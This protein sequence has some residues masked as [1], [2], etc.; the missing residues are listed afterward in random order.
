MGRQQRSTRCSGEQEL[1]GP[2]GPTSAPFAPAMGNAAMAAALGLGGGPIPAWSGDELDRWAFGEDDGEFVDGFLDRVEQAPGRDAAT[3]PALRERCDFEGPVGGV[4]GWI[5]ATVPV[6]VGVAGSVEL[7]IAL[8]LSAEAEMAC[9]FVNQGRGRCEI[10][11]SGGLAGGQDWGLGALIGESGGGIEGGWRARVKGA[12]TLE[13]PWNE[14]IDAETLAL[15]GASVKGEV[16]VAHLVRALADG[17]RGRDLTPYVTKVE[18]GAEGEL[19]LEAEAELLGQEISNVL[20]GVAGLKVGKSYEDPDAAGRREGELRIEAAAEALMEIALDL[21]QAGIDTSAALPHLQ[22]SAALVLPFV[23]TDGVPEY[24]AA[25]AEVGLDLEAG[26]GGIGGTM[27]LGPDHS[28]VSAYV[29]IHPGSFLWQRVLDEA[30]GC[31]LEALTAGIVEFETEGSMKLGM[32]LTLDQDGH[33]S[34][35]TGLI[36]DLYRWLTTGEASDAL[37]PHLPEARAVVFGAKLELE[38]DLIVAALHGEFG[39]GFGA[40]GEV[41]GDLEGDLG[42]VYKRDDV[43]AELRT[44][45]TPDEALAQM[46]GGAA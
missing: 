18:L 39:G 45:L 12:F 32:E 40:G 34:A 27:A 10:E 1:V 22:G 23:E 14:V 3:L 38:V 17:L 9:S 11:A 4:G 2:R 5:D 46:S 33:G 44:P 41:E 25:Y 15:L 31:K 8:G 6:G 13:M 19:G 28:A 37:V 29:M 26:V 24:R 20:K 16:G 30:I 36:A 7:G 21:S 43:L 42:L 35:L